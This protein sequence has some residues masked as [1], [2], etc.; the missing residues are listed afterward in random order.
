MNKFGIGQSV[1]RV[2]DARFLTGRGR[3]LDDMELPRQTHGVVLLSSHAHADIVRI[4]TT[5]AAA[6]P[7][8]LCV[9]TG[10]DVEADGIGAFPTIYIADERGGPPGFRTLRPLLVHD[11]VR[12]VG[13]RVAFVVA[14]TVQQA[15]DAAEQ[16]VVDYAPLPTVMSAEAA[17]KPGATKLWEGCQ[18]NV[19]FTIAFGDKAKT[20]AAF[21]AAHT[22]V[23]L[24]VHNNRVSANPIEPRGAIG[25]YNASEDKYTLYA[26]LSNFPIW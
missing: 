11:R 10:A 16:I 20:D 15:R 18:D 25:D 2:E 26:T 21:A 12:C 17:I 13:D 4:D 6:M 1:R 24:R 8:V 9:L 3:Y 14:E 19:S 22:T 23:S 5:A 7:G